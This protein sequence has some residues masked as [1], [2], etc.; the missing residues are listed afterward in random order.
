MDREV[1]QL[2][3][4]NADLRVKLQVLGDDFDAATTERDDALR[5]ADAAAE[6]YTLAA[7]DRM[8]DHLMYAYFNARRLARE[9]YEEGRQQHA[10]ATAAFVPFEATAAFRN[11]RD[12]DERFWAAMAGKPPVG[13]LYPAKPREPAPEPPWVDGAPV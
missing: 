8:Q 12:L 11:L 6:R 2:A 3:R 1:E 7:L 13:D 4:E 9:A 5:R 10:P